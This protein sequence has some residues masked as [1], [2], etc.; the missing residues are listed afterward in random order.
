MRKIITVLVFALLLG[1]CAKD[2]QVTAQKTF[3]HPA[4]PES[5]N[6]VSIQWKTVQVGDKVYMA[7]PYENSIDLMMY[8]ESLL[9]YINGANNNL[10]YYRR[11]LQEPRCDA[12]NDNEK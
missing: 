3:I 7:L 8:F 2:Q 12:Y 1:G 11:D 5:V 4:W 9:K 6:P 10:C